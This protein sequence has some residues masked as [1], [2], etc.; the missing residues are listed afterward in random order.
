MSTQAQ[1]GTGTA[2]GIINSLQSSSISLPL[3]G[4]VSIISVVIGAG[5]LYLAFG[6][7][8]GSKVINIS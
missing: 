7:K 5:L 4:S 6:R 3:I 2:T 8:K 1:G